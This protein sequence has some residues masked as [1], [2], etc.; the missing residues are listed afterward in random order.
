MVLHNYPG[1]SDG[2]SSIPSMFWSRC[3]STSRS[4][5]P[6]HKKQEHLAQK[7]MTGSYKKIYSSLR[8]LGMKQHEKM[9]NSK[10]HYLGITIFGQDHQAFKLETLF[11]G[12][13]KFIDKNLRENW[14]HYR[15]DHTR[16]SSLAKMEHMRQQTIKANNR[17]KLGTIQI[18]VNISNKQFLTRM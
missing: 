3:S 6:E 14:T 13:T 7:I 12:K 16:L 4:G 8:V 9:N 5:M 10:E 18:Y 17:L 2:R 15:K 1:K 11:L